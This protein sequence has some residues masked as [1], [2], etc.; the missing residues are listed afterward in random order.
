MPR[1][2][3][4]EVL[5]DNES[6]VEF[7]EAL[8]DFHDTFIQAMVKG[9]DFTLRLEVRGIL[10]EMMHARVYADRWRRP[11]GVEARIEERKK[12]KNGNSPGKRF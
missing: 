9:V 10:H 4:S 11:K 1:T 2:D 12:K 6:L 7:E 5:T 3:L 8:K